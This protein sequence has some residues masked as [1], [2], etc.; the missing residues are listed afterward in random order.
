M[1][2]QRNLI[3]L[4][5]TSAL[6]EV[7]F[8]QSTIMPE[9]INKLS[10]DRTIGG[11]F[12]NRNDADKA[13]EAFHELGVLERDIHVIISVNDTIREGRVRVDVHNVRNA[14]HIIEIFDNHKADC[15]LDGSRNLRQDV[16]GMTVGAAAGATAGGTTGTFVAGPVGAAVGVAAGAVVGGGVGAAVGKAKEHLK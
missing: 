2:P 16:A 1:T 3:L 7:S 8:S 6:I 10:N 13:L 5:A 11:V 12:S 14:A 15:N 9:T 4:T